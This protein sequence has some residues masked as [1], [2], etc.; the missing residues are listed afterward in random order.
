LQGNA[1]DAGP[2]LLMQCLATSTLGGRDGTTIVASAPQSNFSRAIH[3][4]AVDI[5]SIA[6]GPM[7]KLAR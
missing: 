1:Q 5:L 4:G 3:R 7:T 2:A 6:R